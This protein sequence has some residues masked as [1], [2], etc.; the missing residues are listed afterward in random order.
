MPLPIDTAGKIETG[1][2]LYAGNIAIMEKFGYSLRAGMRLSKA[3]TKAQQICS[4]CF[5]AGGV[6]PL[7]ADNAINETITS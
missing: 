3:D 2:V 6:I 4:G 7:N 1:D 5:F